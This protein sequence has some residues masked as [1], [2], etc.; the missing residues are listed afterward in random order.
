MSFQNSPL[1][2]LQTGFFEDLLV[3]QNEVTDGK[4]IVQRTGN[5]DHTAEYQVDNQADD[6]VG[7]P[8]IVVADNALPGS[9]NSFGLL[10]AGDG[11]V[12]VPCAGNDEN[13]GET[14]AN[15]D[16]KPNNCSDFFSLGESF[17][18][19]LKIHK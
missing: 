2:E 13:T 8:G 6:D 1:I 3:G 14:L 16:Y 18:C 11:S 19:G 10:K 7:H 12:D 4:H 9:Q 15:A 17:G 5:T